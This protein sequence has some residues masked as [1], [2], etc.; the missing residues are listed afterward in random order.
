MLGQGFLPWL[1][2]QNALPAS[3]YPNSLYP[4]WPGDTPDSCDD[5][6]YRD[7][8]TSYRIQNRFFTNALY[9]PDQLR[10]RVA[11]ALHK[12]VVVSEDALPYPFQMAPYLR[13]LDQNAF[14]NYRDILYQETL[15][16][17]MGEYLNMD[18]STKYDPNENYAREIMQLFAIG[19]ELLNQDGT[20]QNDVNGPLPSYD[21]SVIDEFKRVYTGWYVD[22]V[23]CPA[24]NGADECDDWVNP[25][26]Y[27]PDLHDTDAKTLFAGFPGG[28]VVLA[29]DQT[30][31]QDLNQA[32]DTIFNHPNVGPY[33]A[34]ELI[35]SLVTSNPSHEYVER[36]AGAFNDNGSGVRG[37][38][39]AMVKAILLD[40]EA[41]RE[42]TDPIYGHLKEPVLYINNVLRAFH[43]MSE[44]RT[45]QSDGNLEPYARDAGPEGLE[46]AHGVQ[47]LPAVLR[48]AAGLRGPAR[49][50]VRDHEL[51]DV[52]EARELRQPDDHLGRDRV[53]RRRH[54]LRDLARL[55][56]AAAARVQPGQPRGSAQPS[57]A[58]RHHV[59]RA[60]HVDRDRRQRGRRRRSARPRATG[61]SISSASRRNTRYRGNAMT[62]SRRDFLVRT[63]C[64]AM[65]AAA[66]QASLQKLGLM[67]L[68]AR[69]SA[70]NDYRAMV[71][72]FL[73]GGN[74]SNNMVVP[75]D[76]YYSG[77]Y[78][79]AR[80]ANSGIQI[81]NVGMPG[82]LVSVGAPA[83]LG[84]RTFGFHPSLA[85]LAAL[86]G[87]NKLGVVSNVGPL[88]E[89]V[90]QANIDD[91]QT[92][93]SLFSHSDQID[94]WQTGRADQRISTGWGGRTADVTLN[95]NAGSGFPTITTISGAST[96]C[97][98][99]VPAA[100]RHRHRRARPGARP[101]RLQRLAAGRRAQE[102]DGL[103]PDDRPH[104]EPDRR[105]ERHDAAGRRH[106]RG[107][108]RRPR[109]SRPSSRPPTSATSC[110]R[111]PRS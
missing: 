100:A 105:G 102:L 14:G 52:V 60:A 12:I 92:P 81:P 21:Q 104:R 73:D 70:P 51:A 39:W 84:G 28:P 40:P 23:P 13:A 62:Q 7:N 86:Y 54:A 71:C 82:G 89:P 34:R 83:S 36:V 61:R 57:H 111:W 10:Q 53:R 37:S 9:Q 46:A 49:A 30:G 87:Q 29:A 90:T 68:Y 79:L 77:Q 19:T 43:A 98:G 17:A 96:F 48:R 45:T 22:Q 38:L 32:I 4:L 59:R 108:G 6:C 35:H 97:V 76:A 8:Y 31:A 50:R 72:I 65:S 101:E 80:P 109:R 66:A 42:P 93:Y 47:L 5:T 18:T 26:S 74:D 56:R 25:M 1:A 75:T 94:C 67:N 63:T 27:D 24:P 107:P 69:P 15:N 2:A 95:C 11:W 16:P 99:T 85:E 106:Q 91:K 3:S 88:V 33:L 55:R 41:R 78:A 110:C 58:P 64:A 20:T 44:D 103:R